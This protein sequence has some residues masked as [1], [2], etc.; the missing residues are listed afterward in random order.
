MAKKRKTREQKKIADQ[1][2][3]QIELSSRTNGLVQPQNLSAVQYSFS[4]TQTKS[5][6]NEASSQPPVSHHLAIATISYE[7]ILGD[8]RKTFFITLAIVAA[9]VAL[10]ILSNRIPNL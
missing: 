5:T 7:H 4:N 8:L 2:H 10:F 1:R 6:I 3:Q 9:Q